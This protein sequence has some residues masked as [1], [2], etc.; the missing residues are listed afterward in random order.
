MDRAQQVAQVHGH[1]ERV[2][3]SFPERGCCDL[4]DPERDGNLGDFA[5]GGPTPVRDRGVYF[6]SKRRILKAQ[7]KSVWLHSHPRLI[8]KV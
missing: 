6:V 2:S 4:D 8:E 5:G 3:G 1:G 7:C